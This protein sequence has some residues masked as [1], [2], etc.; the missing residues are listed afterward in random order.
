MPESGRPGHHNAANFL[1]F[2]D[3]IK[4]RP[5]FPV[6]QLT[7]HMAGITVSRRFHELVLKMVDTEDIFICHIDRSVLE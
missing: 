6:I 5:Y 3:I 2:T 4:K 1:H 7:V